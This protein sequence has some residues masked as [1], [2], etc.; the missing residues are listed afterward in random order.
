MKH[1]IAVAT[2]YALLATVALAQTTPGPLRLAGA[3]TIARQL[4]PDLL[5][6]FVATHPGAASPSIAPE[7]TAEGLAAL[8]AGRA[9]LAMATRPVTED[10]RI[11]LLRAGHGDPASSDNARIVALE[12]LAVVVNRDN[13]IS[14]LTLD[15]IRR[16][17]AGQIA[18]WSSLGGRDLPV[19]LYVPDPKSSA[20]DAFAALALNGSKLS[21][22]AVTSDTGKSVAAAVAADPGGIGFVGLADIGAAKPVTPAL[23]CGITI[24]PK[25][26]NVRTEEY[27]LAR[28]LYL[29]AAAPQPPVL[30][31]FL[32]FAASPAA[33]PLIR[34]SG[35]DDLAPE[36]GKPGDGLPRPAIWDPAET[37]RR[38][39]IFAH[40]TDSLAAATRLSP[41]FR[42]TADGT[43]LDPRAQADIARVAAFKRANPTRKLILV[44]YWSG[45]PSFDANIV[46][47]AKH[48][49]SVAAAL[50]AAGA[51]PDQIL[52][53]ST[54][55]PIACAD[56]PN[57]RVEVWVR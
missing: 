27:P 56:E 38:T 50:S 46:A 48:A 16:L 7:T 19:T 34:Q 2:G 29:Y 14:I 37:R 3:P 24:E 55:R 39:Q 52:A 5:S 41:T 49:Q 28:R 23:P 8:A 13:A 40:I 10:E 20:A 54:L 18:N 32:A 30:K 12:S 45:L 36:L 42:F 31:D 53:G 17:F 33:Q 51:R 4:A 43:A 9:T 57:R 22:S 1:C 11:T 6:A 35:L 26:F 25:P 47:S 44:G 15:Q 21:A